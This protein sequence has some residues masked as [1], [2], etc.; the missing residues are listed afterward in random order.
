MP[1]CKAVWQ[2]GR[3]QQHSPGHGLTPPSRGRLA[4]SR[5][6]PLTSNVGP[7]IRR[8]EVAR[9]RVSV[10]RCMPSLGEASELAAAK[11]RLRLWFCKCGF[12]SL[13]R[14]MGQQRDRKSGQA[15]LLFGSRKS[16]GCKCGLSGRRPGPVGGQLFAMGRSGSSRQ[17]CASRSSKAKGSV[18][19]SCWLRVVV[20]HSLPRLVKARPLSVMPLPRLR[21]NPSVKGTS[22]AYAQAAPYLER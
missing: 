22:C 5:K 18:S 12:S 6:T 19:V 14:V 15:S 1:H 13:C 8:V 4:A 11:A 17:T 10:K 2:F 20:R 16:P 9:V 21:P 7:L 3:F